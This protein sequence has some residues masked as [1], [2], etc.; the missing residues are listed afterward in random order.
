MKEVSS[1]YNI[2]LSTIFRYIKSR[3]IYKNEFYF[4]DVNQIKYK[5]LKGYS[6][7]VKQWAS[8]SYFLVQV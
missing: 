1:Y 5:Y 2:T 4:Y 6:L 8:N 7:M 3:K